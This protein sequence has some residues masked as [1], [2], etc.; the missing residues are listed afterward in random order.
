MADQLNPLLE[1]PITHEYR[2][3]E[4]L[5]R[6]EVTFNTLAKACFD[7]GSRTE[8][9]V[10]DVAE[11]V[12]I[13]NKYQ[14]YIARQ[15]VE[16]EKISRNENTRIPVG[17][18]YKSIPGLSNELR[19]KLAEAKPDSI[20]RASRIPGVTPAAISLLLVYL[21]KHQ[22]QQQENIAADIFSKIA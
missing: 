2:L 15:Q 3:S 6:P 7:A 1:T 14:G 21:K 10:S 17:F 20:S 11:Q 16:I 5:A 13:R 19:Q 4:I 8:T 18:I 9:P 12:E 22:Q